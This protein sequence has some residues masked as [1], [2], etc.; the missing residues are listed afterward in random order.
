MK[1]ATCLYAAASA[2]LV[3]G[4]CI[5]F[6]LY[7]R[8]ND[9][10]WYLSN[11]TGAP[12]SWEYFRTTLMNCVD[13]WN[14][15]TGRLCNVVSA[16]FLSLLP[17]WVYA[18]VTAVWL[19]AICMIGPKL[20]RVSYSS[21]GAAAWICCVAFVFPWLDYMFGIVYSINYVWALG[22]VMLALWLLEKTGRVPMW[23]LALLFFV[24]GWWH[25][26]MSVP[27]LAGLMT[28]GILRKGRP[29]VRYRAACIALAAGI[30]VVVLLPAFWH[31]VGERENNLFKSTLWETLANLVAFN[32]MYYV[33]VVLLIVASALRRTR[34]RLLANKREGMALT[35][36]I[37][38]LG[39][40]STLIY[41][42]YFNGPRTG[43]FSQMI[44]AL[45]IIYL[46]KDFTQGQW[47]RLG[48]AMIFVAFAA[49][50]INI[51]WAICVQ[52]KLTQEY[53]DVQRLLSENFDVNGH[54]VYYDHTTMRFG[55]DFMKPSYMALNTHYGLGNVMLLPAALAHFE[56]SDARQTS[57]PQ[58][59]IY[60]NRLVMRGHPT[61]HKERFDVMVT[62][63]DGTTHLSRS[64]L[65]PFRDSSGNPWTYISLHAQTM[66]PALTITDAQRVIPSSIEIN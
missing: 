16:P 22:I 51:V 26:G 50:Y 33:Y 25:E 13:H 28:Y 60:S 35:L 64:L 15:D 36:A 12:G 19:W 46:L 21:A 11:S 5:M 58:L 17:K 37:L 52:R 39:T 3:A 24:A 30:A 62:D 53:N 32:C 44:C 38:A 41:L 34:T 65:R 66:N 47:R 4:Y 29:S 45:G 18:V 55:P 57:D 31:Q 27:L 61:S 23:A 6:M 20:A 48:R 8:F 63:A 9:D 56:E 59:L 40:V 1:N 7:P 2:L 54:V 14:W 10:L 49:A 42:R 43:A